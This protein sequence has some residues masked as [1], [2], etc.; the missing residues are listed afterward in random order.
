MNQRLP[1]AET[2]FEKKTTLRT[3][4]GV[5]RL[6]FALLLAFAV[7]LLGVGKGWAQC[8]PSGQAGS[9]LHYNNC[10]ASSVTFEHTGAT[11]SSK[12]LWS[13]TEPPV[14][15]SANFG[16]AGNFQLTSSNSVN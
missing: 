16:T 9:T 2:K 7:T 12:I 13:A 14:A 3:R 4:A 5:R 1:I 6:P 11:S 10:G 8:T 15:Y